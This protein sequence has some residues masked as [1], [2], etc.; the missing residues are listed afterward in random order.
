MPSRLSP[1]QTRDIWATLQAKAGP[2]SPAKAIKKP[3]PSAADQLRAA[4]DDDDIDSFR[5]VLRQGPVMNADGFVNGRDPEFLAAALDA[6]LSIANP[7]KVWKT[8]DLDYCPNSNR[9]FGIL[10]GAEI[11]LKGPD[12]DQV[13]ALIWKTAL[14]SCDLS[15]IRTTLDY[16]HA[17]SGVIEALWDLVD[18]DVG[19]MEEVLQLCIDKG[20][21]LYPAKMTQRIRDTMDTAVLWTCRNRPAATFHAL[22]SELDH[23]A[24]TA[25]ENP[26]TRLRSPAEAN[27]LWEAAVM[28]RW[29]NEGAD[30]VRILMDNGIFPESRV[31]F[32]MEDDKAISISWGTLALYHQKEEILRLFLKDPHHQHLV[33]EDFEAHPAFFLDTPE[34][35]ET[36]SPNIAVAL[37]KAGIN[38]EKTGRAGNSL[39]H[40][41]FEPKDGG[42]G[43]TDPVL[44]VTVLKMAE[45]HAG[46]MLTRKN[47]K[48]K[49]PVDIA[50]R[51]STRTGGEMDFRAHLERVHLMGMAKQT[52]LDVPVVPVRKARL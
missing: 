51:V 28:S 21:G 43:E 49:T 16:L 34:V 19:E 35:R 22:L 17:A 47:R 50:G 18:D 44:N 30:L 20:V 33:R 32:Q 1:N 31:L 10:L 46:F 7:K 2:F 23:Q 8:L 37:G 6:G 48:G 4:F 26:L 14:D 45:A 41:A 11:G 24:P 27:T 42:F 12:R 40:L 3:Q 13:L 9:L 38:V 25:M 29:S 39:L 15:L 52:P 5:R 36:L